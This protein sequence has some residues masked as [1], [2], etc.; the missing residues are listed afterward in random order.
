MLLLSCVQLFSAANFEA[1]KIQDKETNE[2]EQLF[3]RKAQIRCVAMF[4][5]VSPSEDVTR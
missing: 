4:T 1:A 5:A 3:R 2:V